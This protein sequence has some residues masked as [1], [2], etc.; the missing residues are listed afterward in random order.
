MVVIGVV[1]L[2]LFRLPMAILWP[3]L[4]IIRY[5]SVYT[6]YDKPFF[7]GTLLWPWRKQYWW[8]HLKHCQ[9]WWNWWIKGQGTQHWHWFHN[10]RPYS[11]I[12]TKEILSLIIMKFFNVLYHQLLFSFAIVWA[13]INY[14]IFTILYIIN[15]IIEPKTC[16]LFWLLAWMN[17]LN[18]A[19][20]H[21]VPA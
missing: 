12:I 18:K 13:S 21:L 14:Y 2:L 17:L 16:S 6:L 4:W 10:L 9:K 19:P 11:K 7:L 3:G 5:L 1:S 15:K 8:W 20:V